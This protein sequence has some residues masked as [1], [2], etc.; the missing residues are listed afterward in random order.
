LFKL[1]ARGIRPLHPSFLAM[2]IIRIAGG[3]IGW[4]QIGI[5]WVGARQK[6]PFNIGPWN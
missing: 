1:A 4:A 2:S 5:G 3:E 6:Q